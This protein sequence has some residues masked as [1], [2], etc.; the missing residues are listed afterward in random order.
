MTLL[1]ATNFSFGHKQAFLTKYLPFK[2]LLTNAV[3]YL[4]IMNVSK[5]FAALWLFVYAANSLMV[6]FSNE[7]KIIY[8]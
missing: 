1:N 6:F 7:K 4:I 2:G 5:Y 3:V 8:G